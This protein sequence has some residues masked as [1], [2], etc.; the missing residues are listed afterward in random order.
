[1]RN[2][3]AAD[4]SP[5]LNNVGKTAVQ[6]VDVTIRKTKHE[7]YLKLEHLNPTGSI[8]DRTGAALIEHLERQGRLHTRSVIIEST[9]GNLGVALAFQC[10]ARGYPF[11]AVID[12]KTTLENREKILALGARVDMVQEPDATGGYLLSRLRRVRELCSSHEHY[13]WT[14]QYTNPANPGAHYTHTG[15]EIFDQV[16]GTIDAIFVPVSTG[17]TLAGIGQ[18]FREASPS[19]Q[20]IGVDAY[21]SVIFGTPAAPRKL[22]GIG[23]SRSSHFLQRQFYDSFLLI[24]DEDAFFFCHALSLATHLK[25]GGSSGAVLAACTRYLANHKTRQKVVCVCADGGENYASTIFDERWLQK[26]HIDLKSISAS[27]ANVLFT[28]PAE[29]EK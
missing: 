4:L 12:P 16:P 22:T 13:V 20:I 24:H 25:L 27:H 9:S 18:Y 17:G 3:S 15:P 6:R 2:L 28:L 1:M 21:G 5:S 11:V 19:T 8:K 10:K 7:V 29:T 26:Q 14:D 23:S